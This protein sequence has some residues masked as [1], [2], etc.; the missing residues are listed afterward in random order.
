MMSPRRR[1]A[2]KS[3]QGLDRSVCE[4]GLGRCPYG[5]GPE[6]TLYGVGLINFIIVSGSIRLLL[7]RHQSQLSP[8][9]QCFDEHLKEPSCSRLHGIPIGQC[10]QFLDSRS[11]IHSSLA[12]SP[13]AYGST[14]SG[15]QAWSLHKCW[16]VLRVGVVSLMKKWDCIPTNPI[17]KHLESDPDVFLL[18]ASA[19][20]IPVS[21]L[22][23]D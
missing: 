7:P 18:C 21:P 23:V 5:T 1:S 16:V 10:P 22:D 2:Q 20:P 12:G 19:I 3:C 11:G 13:V 14:I 6:P 17:Y 8:S 9:L 15:K 4:N